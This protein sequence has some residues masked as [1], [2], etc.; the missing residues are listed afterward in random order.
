MKLPVS[1][2]LRQMRCKSSGGSC[3]HLSSVSTGISLWFDASMCS[4]TSKGFAFYTGGF[5]DKDLVASSSILRLRSPQWHI[6]SSSCEQWVSMPHH[7]VSMPHHIDVLDLTCHSL[8]LMVIGTY[9]S[10][11]PYSLRWNK[12][13]SLFPCGVPQL[14]Y[15]VIARTPCG[16]LHF[17]CQITRP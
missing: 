4:T 6:M 12:K 13:C 10:V 7:W 17:T 3:D 8:L 11:N 9:P 1:G 5:Q 2:S 15:D 14:H 16:F